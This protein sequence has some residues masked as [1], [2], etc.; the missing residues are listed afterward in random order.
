MTRGWPVLPAV[1]AVLLATGCS[2]V[3]AGSLKA[4]QLALHGRPELM[5]SAA[6]V[7]ANPFPQMLVTHREGSAVLVLADDDDG[8]QAWYD[9]AGGIVFLRNGLVTGT[10]GGTPQLDGMA[11]L[12]ADPFH[13]L[14]RT[15]AGTRVLRRYD[16]M[17]G[18][19]YGQE[20]VGTLDPVGLEATS[21]LGRTRMLLHVRETL[22]GPQW[23]QRNHY[24]VDPAD[25]FIWKSRQAIATDAHLDIVHLKPYRPVRGSR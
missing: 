5:P 3:G 14:H 4:L 1:V 9:Q 10:H 16:V 19:H 15:P 11:I 7:A 23:R 12:G 25:G 6:D 18:Y 13:A 8:L 21:L 24:W 22:Q 17:P 2:A 20:V